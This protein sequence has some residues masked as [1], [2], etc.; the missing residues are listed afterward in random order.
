[1]LKFQDSKKN[2]SFTL[3]VPSNSTF[4]DIFELVFK[5]FNLN[6]NDLPD[7]KSAKI[8]FIYKSVICKYER[9]PESYQIGP[10]D[11]ITIYFPKLLNEL[12]QKQST[13]P[14]STIVK[15]EVPAMNESTENSSTN[16]NQITPE[17][18]KSHN[19]REKIVNQQISS[20]HEISSNSESKILNYVNPNLLKQLVDIGF[21]Q[22]DAAY[23]IAYKKNIN[24]AIDFLNLGLSSDPEVRSHIDHIVAAKQMSDNDEIIRHTLEN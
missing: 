3:E 2:I 14:S 21:N 20:P 22:V 5:H 16:I 15:P 7:E 23:A 1:M 4:Y 8:K 24:S 18:Q 17:I 11:T 12:I 9:T 6:K 10:Q 13:P 19:D